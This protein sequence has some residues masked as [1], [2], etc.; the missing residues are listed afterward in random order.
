MGLWALAMR[1]H[2]LLQNRY[3]VEEFVDMEA[4][5][6]KKHVVKVIE[7]KWDIS[8]S[9]WPPRAKYADSNAIHD[10]DEHM[11]RVLN[12]D[13]MYALAE[14]NTE[15]FIVKN[16][17]SSTAIEDCRA[18][19]HDFSRLIYSVYDFYAS[20]GTGEPFTIQLNAYSRFLEET[21]LINNKSQ[22]V[23]KSAFDLLFKAVNQ[24]SGNI[25]ALDRI[26][27][28]QVL[29]RIAKMK[30]IDQ[31]IEEHMAVALRRVL[32]RDIEEKVD[33]RALHDATALRESYCYTQEVDEVL[34]QYK[35]SLFS[36]FKVCHRG[37]HP[38]RRASQ[39]VWSLT[40]AMLCA[41]AQV[42]Q[43]ARL[44]GA[45]QPQMLRTTV[46]YALSQHSLVARRPC[47]L[48]AIDAG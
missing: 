45:P 32:E 16:C 30:Y 4:L 18:V 46:G 26:G 13:M 11:I 19:L 40:I 6:K 14:H 3:F 20:L 12:K 8:Q 39:H 9:I 31:G 1:R 15:A 48:C 44:G 27:W 25:H 21:E 47:A 5:G 10:T 28:L 22:H 17:K 24:G 43:A 35:D 7:K 2:E 38:S 29:I 41:S 23:N 33:G 42:D 36:L 37:S 34:K